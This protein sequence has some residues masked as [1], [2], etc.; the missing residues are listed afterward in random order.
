MINILNKK[1]FSLNKRLNK[2]NKISKDKSNILKVRYEEV[3][4]IYFNKKQLII[5]NKKT[6]SNKL[7]IENYFHFQNNT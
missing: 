3:N 6:K 7:K 5:L 4:Q 2:K 1:K